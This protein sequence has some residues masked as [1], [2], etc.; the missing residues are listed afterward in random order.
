MG[1]GRRKGIRGAA[2]DPGPIALE[3]VDLLAGLAPG[4][5]LQADDLPAALDPD[6][7]ATASTTVA[8]AGRL[9]RSGDGTIRR[10]IRTRVLRPGERSPGRGAA[11]TDRAGV[12]PRTP[13]KPGE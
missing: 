5:E 8:E 6:G 3:P 13:D 9:I 11:E 10:L 1:R 12:L 7:P 4:L 2:E